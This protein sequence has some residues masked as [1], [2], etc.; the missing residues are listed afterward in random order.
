MHWFS[1]NRLGSS[2][3][4]GATSFLPLY[5]PLASGS[6]VGQT[7]LAQTGRDLTMTMRW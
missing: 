2:W 7:I 4:G 6:E 5:G 3:N 1:G